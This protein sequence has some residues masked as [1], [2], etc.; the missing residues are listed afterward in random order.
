MMAQQSIRQVKPF[1]AARVSCYVPMTSI[2]LAI[3][4]L[5]SPALLTAQESAASPETP[6]KSAK[7][8]TSAE[9]ELLTLLNQARSE[10]GL[11]P[12]AVDPRLTQAARK[13]SELMAQQHALSHQFSGEP[14]LQ[15][16]F[17]D[18]GL[19]S[20]RQAE[21]VDLDQDAASAHQALMHSPPHRQN[22]LDPD[23]NA[24]G[25]GVVRKGENIYVTEDFA[26]RL[27]ELSEPQAESEVQSAINQYEG[28][29]G[30]PAPLRKP[31][32]ELRKRACDLSLNDSLND[33]TTA[34]LPGARAVFAWTAGD[35]NKLPKA[36]GRILDAGLP[37]G[38]SLGACFAPSV[39]HP[40]GVYWLVMVSY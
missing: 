33:L 36:M 2:L 17:A 39:S 37:S 23:Y 29:R 9:A 31:Q 7:F 19:P 34:Q 16:R 5:L 27:P 21:N 14:A 22:I 20:D 40:G 30:L 18:E 8:D 4:L 26:R 24:I 10:L 12:L 6:S 32:P 15:Q 13:H 38:Y 28:A 1:P 25:I 11:Q 35:P 3:A